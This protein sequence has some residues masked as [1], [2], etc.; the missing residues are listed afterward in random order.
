MMIAESYSRL[1]LGR[2]W[3][4]LHL[5]AG[6]IIPGY[7]MSVAGMFEDKFANN[8]PFSIHSFVMKGAALGHPIGQWFSPTLLARVCFDLSQEITPRHLVALPVENG[9]L[10]LPLIRNYLLQS[11]SILL[12]CP[13][14]LGMDTFNPVYLDLVTGALQLSQS[15]GIIGGKPGKCFHIVGHQM[16]KELFYLDPHVIKEPVRDMQEAM[17]RREFHTSQVLS[18]E[19]KSLDPCLLFGFLLRNIQ[20]LDNFIQ[21]IIKLNTTAP[22]F[23]VQQ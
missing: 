10:N 17:Q 4:H 21:S 18:M 15:V 16:K 7:Y 6:G 23:S 13:L 1:L 11:H 22:V 2:G 19:P 8:V 12:M 9:I 20:D 14:R 5:E 3:S